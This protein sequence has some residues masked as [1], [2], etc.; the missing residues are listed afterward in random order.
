MRLIPAAVADRQRLSRIHA[1]AGMRHFVHWN[2]FWLD[3][4]LADPAIGMFLLRAGPR[5]DVV[6]CLA[7]GP[8]EP[9]DLDP[10][11]RVPTLGEL[12]HLVIDRRFVGRG[13]GRAAIEAGTAELRARM[14]MIAAIRVAHH[15]ENVVAAR[16]Y[17]NLGFEI[18]GE[19]VDDETGI[20][21]VLRGRE[22]YSGTELTTS[23]E[24]PRWAG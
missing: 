24:G 22:L 23:N 3:R 17:E 2:H 6:G 10:S 18:I 9:V 15:P 11:S 21:D 4:A 8:H 20:C 16:L 5:E 1:P 13:H 19:K 14:P 12:F 7:I